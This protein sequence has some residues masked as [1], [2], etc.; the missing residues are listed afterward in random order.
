MIDFNEIK[1][2]KE[3][4]TTPK[5]LL[6]NALHRA[7]EFKNVLI[8]TID[9]DDEIQVGTSESDSILKLLGMTEV[10]RNEL[11]SKLFEEQ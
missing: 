6:T 2:Q 1:A 5:S 7:N 4:R 8:V 3:G 9:E 10:A 11:L